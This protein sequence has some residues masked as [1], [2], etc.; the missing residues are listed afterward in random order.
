MSKTILEGLNP[1]QKEAVLHSGGPLLILAGAGSG[2][3]KVIVH[4]FAHLSCKVSPEHILAVTFTNKA[5]G[6]MKERIS[7]LIKKDIRSAWVGTFHSQCN[8]ILRKEIHALGYGCDFSILDDSDQLNLIRHILKEFKMYEALYR[9]I[10]SRISLL[11]SSFV[12][13]EEFLSRGDVFGF[14]DKIARVYLRYQDEIKRCNSLDFDDLILLTIKLFE[15]HP[16]ALKKFQD[17]FQHILIDEFQDTNPAQYR[18][19]KLLAG[20]S[21]N[22]CA[23]GDD[24]QSIYAFR[25]ADHTNIM[26]FE[27]DFKGAKVI[28]LEQN[29]RSTQHILDIAHHVINKNPYRHPKKLWTDRKEGEKPSLC[30]FGNEIEE[31]RHIAK[32]ARELYLKGAY[33]YNDFAVLYRVNLQSRAIEEA[34][35]EERL[36]YRIIG[37]ISFYQ[38]KEIKDLI[39]YMRLCS[40]NSNNVSLRRIINCPPRGIGASTLTKIDQIAKKKSVSLLSA[41]KEILKTNTV[42]AAIK[43]KI[44][45]FVGIVEGASPKN[46]K[47]AS[48][49][50]RHLY[51]NTG[52]AEFIGEDRAENTMELIAS[53]EGIGIEAF[54]DKMS[55]LSSLDSA[56]TGNAVSLL[57]FHS[58]KG[59]EF[60]VVFISGVEEGILP[61][62]KAQE[63]KEIAEERRLLYVGMT[64]A[65]EML[66]LT[67][68]K[69][70]RLYTKIQEQQPSRFLKDIPLEC[71]QKIE[72]IPPPAK[73][74][75]VCE[76]K[77]KT[78]KAS[79]YSVGSR[80]KHSTWG[81]GVVRDCCGEGDDQKITVNFPN[82]GIKKLALKFAQIERL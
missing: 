6:E 1:A 61:Y 7:R 38:R 19:M 45:G 47:T 25:G 73:P 26:N 4:R 65:K 43:E 36:P 64:R 50:L 81:V 60:P 53:A 82:V 30:W 18:L 9:G 77:P 31:A 51:K 35:R 62:L 80:I 2:K 11:K 54:L 57:T 68:A 71:C 55:L 28:K 5:A 67:C 42:T 21:G 39:S 52:Y 8:K 72:K 34:L 69:K 70:R 78:F 56:D 59:L 24:D 49:M 12:G 76:K 16:K 14:E 75:S 66:W 17:S 37:G 63:P 29:Y 79:L 33:A 32:T 23:V 41:M 44:A 10:L 74:G 27:K 46:F 48:D 20:N 22:M 40:N 58:A 3:T 15:E 13:P